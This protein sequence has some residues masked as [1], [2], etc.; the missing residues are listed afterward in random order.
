M[1]INS[2][3]SIWSIYL[4]FSSIHSGNW[5]KP[6]SQHFVRKKISVWMSHFNVS[7]WYSFF[8]YF[9]LLNIAASSSG[10]SQCIMCVKQWPDDFLTAL[11][12]LECHHFIESTRFDGI[13]LFYFPFVWFV[14]IYF[15]PNVD[16]RLC[17]GQVV[18]SNLCRE[19]GGSSTVLCTYATNRQRNKRPCSKVGGSD[20]IVLFQPDGLARFNVFYRLWWT[21][22]LIT[23]LALERLPRF[24]HQ[25][26]NPRPQI[27]RTLLIDHST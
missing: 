21:E 17:N 4:A 10:Y 26:H 15:E 12:I 6:V 11:S 8:S 5:T 16:R 3:N 7:C 1:V 13:R 22:K 24:G 14:G 25:T 23:E 18:D 2:R 20:C 9:I 19:T 27:M